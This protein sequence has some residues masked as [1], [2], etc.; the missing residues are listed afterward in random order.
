MK[1]DDMVQRMKNSKH[2][3]LRQSCL[4]CGTREIKFNAISIAVFVV[5]IALIVLS[6]AESPTRPQRGF[7][8]K[9][10][11]DCHGKKF[12]DLKKP[13]VHGPALKKDC[14]VC[15]DR[16]GKIPIRTFKKP[17]AALCYTCHAAEKLG[18]SE[19]GAVHTPIKEGKCIPCH[20]PHAG[21]NKL[22][23]KKQGNSLCF[24]CHEETLFKGA[25]VHAPVEKG[26]L[27]CHSPHASPQADH[28]VKPETELCLGC[29]NSGS[30]SFRAAHQNYPV[31]KA[32]CTGCHD[33]HATAHPK[34]LRPSIHKP[35]AEKRC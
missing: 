21:D 35:L 12:D 22:F 18:I 27:T 10:C 6:C 14:E 7:A 30:A 34:L 31:E 8:P 17:G 1:A 20:A 32:H 24:D 19:K 29:H 16:H 5:A 25:K 23:L 26:C 13:Y 9:A 3:R 4:W 28:L 15:H 11:L 2:V 33:P